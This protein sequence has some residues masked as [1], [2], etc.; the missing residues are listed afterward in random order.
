MRACC[1]PVCGAIE[2]GCDP[3]GIVAAASDDSGAV[4]PAAAL[5]GAAVAAADDA[6]MPARGGASVAIGVLVSVHG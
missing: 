6:C 2:K 1:L 3:D 4:P 5:A